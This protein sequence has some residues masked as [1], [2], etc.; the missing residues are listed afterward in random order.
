MKR[1]GAYHAYGAWKKVKDFNP[2]LKSG[3]RKGKL[4]DI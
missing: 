4:N 1:K 2:L 3:K